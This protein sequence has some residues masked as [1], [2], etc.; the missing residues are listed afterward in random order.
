MPQQVIFNQI[1]EIDVLEIIDQ[2]M[3]VPQA[4]EVVVKMHACGLNR[5]EYLFFHGQYLFQPVFPAKLGMEGAGRIQEVGEAVN[6]FKIGDRVGLL[7]SVDIVRYG[8]LGEY[9]VVPEAHLIELPPSMS[10]EK[11]AAFWVA[12]G[13]AYGVLIQRG[14]LLNQVN[15]IVVITAASSSVGVACIQMAKNHG[16]MVI[17]TTRTSAKKDFLLQL[18]ADVVIATQE[19]DLQQR[20]MTVTEGKGFDIA[21]DPITGSIITELAEVAAAEAR[22]VLYG[23]LNPEPASFPILSVLRKGLQISGFHLGLHLLDDEKKRKAMEQ[24]LNQAYQEGR[25]DILIDRQFSLPEVQA[26]Y[27]YMESN[28]QKGKIVIKV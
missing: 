21:V 22:L 9:V 8:F 4:H 28:K 5:A 10:F 26:A 18:G 13:T 14:G 25:L 17:A 7:P 2:P 20:I 1:G 11:A 3:P 15:P 23:I 12:Y 16:A 6:R 19:E 24:Y 27:R